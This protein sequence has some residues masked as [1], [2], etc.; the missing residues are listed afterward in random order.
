MKTVNPV[1]IRI[2]NELKDWAQNRSALNY[3]SLSG[4][5]T[6]ILANARNEELLEKGVKELAN[7]HPRNIGTS[8]FLEGKASCDDSENISDV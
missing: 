3:R 4:E 8:E 6:A 2:P 1:S 5:V 7:S